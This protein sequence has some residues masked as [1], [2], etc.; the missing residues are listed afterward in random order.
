M[1]KEKTDTAGADNSFVRTLTRPAAEPQPHAVRIKMAAIVGVE[2]THARLVFCHRTH[3]DPARQ[4]VAEQ[5]DR[6]W[7]EEG[8][9]KFYARAQ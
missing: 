7:P 1:F 8:P 2:A 3:E 5:Q 9:T 4:P 6:E